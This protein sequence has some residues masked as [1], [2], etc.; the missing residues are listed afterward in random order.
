MSDDQGASAPTEEPADD[1]GSTNDSGAVVAAPVDAFDADRARALIDK[2][3]PFEKEANSLRQKYAKAEAR[4]RELE[5]VA[6][7]HEA[8]AAALEVRTQELALIAA[9]A[10]AGTPHPHEVARLLDAEKLEYD[11][12]GNP[13]NIEPLM[14][15]LKERVPALFM[16]PGSGDG[17]PRGQTPAGSAPGMEALLRKAAK[18]G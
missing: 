10:A 17:G 4:T 11:D 6:S 8:R 9:V 12:A 18:G 14:A 13:T 3:R 7:S 5:A 1:G 16:R 2:L 15:G